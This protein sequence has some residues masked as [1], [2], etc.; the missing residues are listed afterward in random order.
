[1]KCVYV[2]YQTKTSLMPCESTRTRSLNNVSNLTLIFQ[3]NGDCQ[4]G[5]R[6]NKSTLDNLIRL[7]NNRAIFL[8]FSKAFD[9]LW[10]DGLLLILRK[11]NLHGHIY[12]AIKLLISN[13]TIHVRIGDALSQKYKIENGVPHGSILSPLFF[14]IF[15]NDFPQTNTILNHPSSLTIATS[16]SKAAILNIIYQQLYNYISTKFRNGAINGV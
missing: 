15:I 12:H 10:R 2:S 14:L 8:D 5:F 16:G 3:F 6:K 9:M 1:M 11:L 4:S 7:H 13:R